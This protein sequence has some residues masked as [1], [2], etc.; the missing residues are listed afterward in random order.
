MMELLAFVFT[1]PEPVIMPVPEPAP[2]VRVAHR[3][4]GRFEPGPVGGPAR[5]VG[6]GTR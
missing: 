1:V 5:T 2:V 3:G 4:S 6:G